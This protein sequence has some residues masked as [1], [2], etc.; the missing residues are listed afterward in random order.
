MKELEDRVKVLQVKYKKLRE[1][2]EKLELII[3][4]Y[5]IDIEK[6]KKKIKEKEE[7]NNL[8]KENFNKEVKKQKDAHDLEIN[9]L[10]EN[11]N[12]EVKKHDLEIQHLKNRL[13]NSQYKYLDSVNEC[14]E[15]KKENSEL[16]E[17]MNL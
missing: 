2:K 3:E 14:M 16:K 12:K 11:F 5:T 17:K 8:L 9:L 1:E 6:F 13:I 4:Q 15:L 7:D 10:K